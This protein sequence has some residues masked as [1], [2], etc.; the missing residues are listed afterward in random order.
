MISIHRWLP[1]QVGLSLCLCTSTYPSEDG[2]FEF[3]K[4]FYAA[5]CVKV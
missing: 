5:L 1:G 2:F 4:A 3:V